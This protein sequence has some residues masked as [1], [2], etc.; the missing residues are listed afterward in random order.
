MRRGE[1]VADLMLPQPLT[2][3]R[4]EGTVDTKIAPRPQHVHVEHSVRIKRKDR[5]RRN[6]YAALDEVN[7]HFWSV[8]DLVTAN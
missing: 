1:A 3:V 5:V 2:Q 6:L 4:G 8:L 7:D